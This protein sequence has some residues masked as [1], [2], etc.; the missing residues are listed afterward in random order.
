MNIRDSLIV[1]ALA[2]AVGAL[3]ACA[4]NDNPPPQDWSLLCT[5]RTACWR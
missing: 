4:P 3:G 1:I 2:L 5:P